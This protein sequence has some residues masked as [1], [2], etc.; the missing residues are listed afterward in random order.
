MFNS[1]KN[2][3]FIKKNKTHTDF[4]SMNSFF[5]NGRNN[6]VQLDMDN[7]RNFK[8]L[9]KRE[10][11]KKLNKYKEDL[12]KKIELL[13]DK[14][15]RKDNNKIIKEENENI[16]NNKITII[17]YKKFIET[18]ILN[19]NIFLRITNFL[20]TNDLYRLFTLNNE[21]HQ[22]I[23]LNL[24]EISKEKIIPNYII[25][26]NND[27]L[28]KESKFFL[29][30]KKYKKN[31]KMNLRV[32]FTIKSKITE[33]NK[34]IINN[35]YQ[36]SFKNKTKQNSGEIIK[37]I[38][39]YTF[40]I[41]DKNKKKNFWIFKEYTSFY[42]DELDRAYYGNILEFYPG[43]YINLSLTIFSEI[44]LIDF[45]SFN[46]IKLKEYYD[47]NRNCEIEN[48]K[49]SWSSINQIENSDIVIQNIKNI[50]I[51]NFQV[52]KIFFD[53]VGYYIFKIILKAIKTGN[54][55]GKDNNIG[56]LINIFDEGKNVENEVKKNGLIFDEKNEININIGDYITFYISQ[57]K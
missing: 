45:E 51:D 18:Y 38:S 7:I 43:D 32:V 17:N 4:S 29:I 48:L 22:G 55:N 37:T 57:N 28:F 53:D 15:Y 20:D 41:I 13:K 19:K 11:L 31:K 26:Y 36:I 10:N 21:I 8:N 6:T 1:T 42:F 54:S 2:F 24:T 14:L 25:K 30:F 34:D 46:W 9:I 5:S 40:D 39:S 44:G 3:D 27:I 52:D 56:I 35:S 50:F 23:I 16:E 12:D 49:N 33:N 47:K